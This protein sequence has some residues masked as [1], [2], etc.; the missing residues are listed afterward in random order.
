MHG[1]LEADTSLGKSILVSPNGGGVGEEL[2]LIFSKALMT[3]QANSKETGILLV[4]GNDA[5]CTLSP[6]GAFT[7]SFCLDL[8]SSETQA[9]DKE[10]GSDFWKQE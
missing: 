2:G 8:V 1:S 4:F 9:L 7:D 5:V 3:D 6:G 10:S